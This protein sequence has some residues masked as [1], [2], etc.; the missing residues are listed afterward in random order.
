MRSCIEKETMQRQAQ[1]Q[2]VGIS[3]ETLRVP[4]IVH[5][6]VL[7]FPYPITTKGEFCAATISNQRLAATLGHVWQY[8]NYS[9]QLRVGL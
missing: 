9:R 2:E 6:N 8:T 5:S 4:G 3:V 7:R 1:L